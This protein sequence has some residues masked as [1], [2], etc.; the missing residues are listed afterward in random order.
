MRLSP[1]DPPMYY[2]TQ[3]AM[4]Y[5]HFLA[6]RYDAAVSCAES[7]LR[8]PTNFLLLTC[9][10]AASNILAGRREPAERAVLQA[11]E[12]NPDLHANLRNLAP[13]RREEDF[14]TFAKGL[15]D[16]GLPD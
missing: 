10:S 3:G 1:L 8:G 7:A 14:A 5:A 2:E 13:F 4:A 11:L 12:R 9:I 15:R 6:G 16:A